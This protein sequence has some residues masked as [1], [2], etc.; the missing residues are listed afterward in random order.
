MF[1]QRQIMH[2]KVEALELLEVAKSLSQIGWVDANDVNAKYVL[3]YASDV[4][5]A[6]IRLIEEI[7]RLRNNY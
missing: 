2:K 7:E 5:E 3:E 1:N 4:S 6:Y